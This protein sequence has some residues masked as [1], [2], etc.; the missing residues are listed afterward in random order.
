[1]NEMHEMTEARD[2]DGGEEIT[3]GFLTD[4]QIHAMAAYAT[5]HYELSCEWRKA[6][7]AAREYAIEEWG[8]EPFPAALGLT[9]KLARINWERRKMSARA[10]VGGA[11]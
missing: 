9:I 6:R 3:H 7:D 4:R 1:M 10:A 8:V 5:D 11:A 2:Q